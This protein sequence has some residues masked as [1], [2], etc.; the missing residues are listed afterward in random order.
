M[1]T[2]AETRVV[3]APSPD[4]EASGASTFRFDRYA[5]TLHVMV[6]AG[7]GVPADSDD[8]RFATHERDLLA[9]AYRTRPPFQTTRLAVA[10]DA[11]T[12]VADLATRSRRFAVS[13][14]RTDFRA[15]RLAV[16]NLVLTPCASGGSELDEHDLIS[17]AGA[18]EETAEPST[19]AF[20]LQAEAVTPMG[21]VERALEGCSPR[22]LVDPETGDPYRVGTMHLIGEVCE[23]T[24]LCSDLKLL[25]AENPDEARLSPDGERW[26]NLVALA[27]IMRGS[28][29]FAD[30][31]PHELSSVFKRAIIGKNLVTVVHKGTLLRI[32]GQARCPSPYVLIPHAI[33]LHNEQRLEQAREIVSRAYLPSEAASRTSVAGGLARAFS[34][35]TRLR[36]LARERRELVTVL[37]AEVVPNVIDYPNLRLLYEHGHASR[38]LDELQATLRRR[39][40]ELTHRMDRGLEEQRLLG[41]DLLTVFLLLLTGV[42]MSQQFPTYLVLPPLVLFGLAFL[43]W[44]RLDLAATG[45]PGQSAPGPEEQP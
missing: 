13:A 23:H 37:D 18:W 7:T 16:L 5:V 39:L 44:R 42:Q 34:A 10:S 9:Y 24:P 8:V 28:S 2:L 12:V 29:A 41:Q 31:A 11:A 38:G 15:S 36:R 45:R 43:I 3:E 21:L 22:L 27:G 35:P 17:L 26:A 14:Y 30:T 4:G 1:T 25:K 32:S 20:R 33:V 40:D 6:P 19:M